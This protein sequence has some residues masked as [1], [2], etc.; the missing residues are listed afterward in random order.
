MNLILAITG[1]VPFALFVTAL[2]V[3][4]NLMMLPFAYLA[5]L[6]KK[7]QLV[8]RQSIKDLLVFLVIG[9]LILFASIFKDASEFF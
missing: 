6:A 4:A 8:N 9:W 2:Y 7:I 5:A 3:P 1:Y